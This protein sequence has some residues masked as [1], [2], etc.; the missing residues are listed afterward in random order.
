[1]YVSLQGI[2]ATQLT[3]RSWLMLAHRMT[4]GS[5][6]KNK[7]KNRLF[8]DQ[9]MYLLIIVEEILATD[10]AGKSFVIKVLNYN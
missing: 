5:K 2:T 9:L 7:K 4:C 3:K 10:S 8:M 1:M 6:K